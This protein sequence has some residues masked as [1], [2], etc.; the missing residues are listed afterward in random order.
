M[1]PRLARQPP[2]QAGFTLAELLVYLTLS[3]LVMAS[4]YQLLM[5]QSRAYG[6]QRELMDVHETL[7]TA[8]AL[9]AWEI[10]Q[11]SATDGDLYSI[12]ETSITLRSVQGSGFICVGHPT[13]PRFGLV[14]RWRF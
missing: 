2:S 9:L 8:A 10:R 12:G 13:L 7:R 6:R 5:G 4:V 14:D 3:G 1:K 11:A